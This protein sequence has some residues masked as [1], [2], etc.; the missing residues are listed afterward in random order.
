MLYSGDGGGGGGRG[1]LT[2]T[3]HRSVSEGKTTGLGG[4]GKTGVLGRGSGGGWVGWGSK[5]H[6]SHSP[7]FVGKTR[8]IT[9]VGCWWSGV[10]VC[11][12]GGGGSKNHTSHM[13]SSVSGG[14]CAV[15][16]GA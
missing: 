14:E 11:V 4:V 9:R 3:S 7:V 10:C 16:C 8:V 15:L 13:H 1:V 12:C 5:N 2:V 6:T